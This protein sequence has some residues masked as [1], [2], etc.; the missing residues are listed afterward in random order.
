MILLLNHFSCHSKWNIHKLVASKSDLTFMVHS[1]CNKIVA[2]DFLYIICCQFPPSFFIIHLLVSHQCSPL[3]K[4]SNS[5]STQLHVLSCLQ[6]YY[7]AAFLVPHPSM[8]WSNIICLHLEKNV[9]LSFYK[10]W[11]AP[12]LS[13][14]WECF[15]DLSKK[16]TCIYHKRS[17]IHI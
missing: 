9:L 4:G 15:H 7:Y 17:I 10:Q 14:G 5:Q 6:N 1:S 16:Y 3:Y 8:K 2:Y 12:K 13:P 11:K